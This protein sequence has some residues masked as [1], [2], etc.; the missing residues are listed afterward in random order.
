MYMKTILAIITTLALALA[1]TSNAAEQPSSVPSFEKLEETAKLA[2]E[3]ALVKG[4]QKAIEAAGKT[5]DIVVRS[6]YLSAAAEINESVG[7]LVKEFKPQ[8]DAL[9]S[10][11]KGMG[12]VGMLRNPNMFPQFASAISGWLTANSEEAAKAALGDIEG[13]FQAQL[14]FDETY[15]KEIMKVGGANSTKSYSEQQELARAEAHKAADKV[16]S[17]GK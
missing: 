2:L 1:A 16:W 17:S 3:K 9:P 8:I 5:L 11:I 12:S 4:D 7:T 13:V 10:L 15:S 6:R 14:V